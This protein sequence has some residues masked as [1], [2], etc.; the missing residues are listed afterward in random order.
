MQLEKQ[1]E[2]QEDYWE[3]IESLGGYIYGTSRGISKGHIEPSDEVSGSIE[4][5]RKIQKGLVWDIY[6]KFGVIP[7]EWFNAPNDETIDRTP[8]EPGKQYWDWYREQKKLFAKKEYEKTICS[9]CPF[10]EGSEKSVDRVPCS[11]HP[12][13]QMKLIFPHRCGMYDFD[14]FGPKKLHK[15]MSEEFGD[16]AL[17]IFLNKE[18]EL[19]NSEKTETAAS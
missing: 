5:A 15:K 13:G 12:G 11:I 8:E 14:T 6:K 18:E 1:P 9:A 7:P 4:D 2:T 10:S 3:A 19:R 16:E 17:Q